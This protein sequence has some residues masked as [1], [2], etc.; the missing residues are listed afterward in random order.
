MPWIALMEVVEE[1]GQEE[2]VGVLMT[3]EREEVDP[4]TYLHRQRYFPRP[5]TVLA[6]KARTGKSLSITILPRTC[7]LLLRRRLM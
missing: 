2:G 5:P 1:D 4:P 7:A 3:R 6:A